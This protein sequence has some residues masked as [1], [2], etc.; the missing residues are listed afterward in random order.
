MF[1][2]DLMV[3][4]VDTPAAPPSRAALA[5]TSIEVMFG[6]ILAMKGILVWLVTASQY[7]LTSSG[8]V[9]TSE[10]IAWLV[11]CGQEKLPS[12]RGHPS[13]SHI[14]ANCFHSS[15]LEPMMEATITWS[16]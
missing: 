8:F 14:L 15:S 13:S 12:I 7:F 1:V 10:P 5:G 16:G 6:V 9:P 2:M 4:I 11:I 3:L